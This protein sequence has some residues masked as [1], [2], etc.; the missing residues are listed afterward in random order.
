M[1]TE[2]LRQRTLRA[3]VR[4]QGVGLHTGAPVELVLR[5]APVDHGV[6]FRRVDLPVPV[7]VRV[8]PA[9]VCDASMASTLG[10]G[11]HRVKTV[12][13]LMS[14]VSGLGIDNLEVEV[15]AEEIPIM[16]GSASAFVH[17][18][19]TAG[20]VPQKA[21]KRFVRVKSAVEVRL[22]GLPERWARLEPFE[23]LRLDFAIDF[24]H[25]AVDKTGQHFTFELGQQSF[26]R[27][28]ARARTF[29]FASDVDMLRHR[30]LALGGSL[31]NAIVVDDN[32]VL[33][34]EGLRIGEE[35]VRHKVLDALGDLYLLGHPLI[36][37]YQGHRAGHAVNNQL[38]RALVA[39]PDAWE[40]V[41]FQR[42]DDAPPC[43]RLGF[44]QLA[45]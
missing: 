24:D 32:R 5:P 15:N 12:E 36:G 8:S 41:S 39:A 10:L 34:L 7:S 18:L 26:A 30:G 21:W 6:V 20:V 40:E 17:L 25:A 29:C 42:L 27:D 16:D 19:K 1:Q 2:A 23:G 38:L 45:F 13:H 35:F 22:A 37:K 33:N 3:V 43:Y 28:V 44:E 9:A 31:D 14:A 4:A 11:E